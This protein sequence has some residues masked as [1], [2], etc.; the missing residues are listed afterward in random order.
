MLPSP[1]I[2]TASVHQCDGD[3]ERAMLGLRAP[4]TAGRRR[5]AR[6]GRSGR[7]RA[8][9][10]PVAE[11]DGTQRRASTPQTQTGGDRQAGPAP[12]RAPINPVLAMQRTAGNQAVQRRIHAGGVPARAIVGQHAALGNQAVQRLLRRQAVGA[13][14]AV[15]ARRG[16]AAPPA[17]TP[18]V[19][20]SPALLLRSQLHPPAS[21]AP[22]VHRKVDTMGGEWFDDAYSVSQSGTRR[23]ATMH[24]R[25]KP[26]PAVNA[27]LIGLTQS[28]KSL[29]NKT[30]FYPNSDAFYKGRAIKSGD[31]ITTNAATGETDEG[32]RIDQA[33]H[34]R[35][36]LYAAEGAPA[37]DTRLSDTLPVAGDATKSNQWGRHGFRFKDAKGATK[38]QDATLEDTPGI[39]SVDVSKNSGQ[40]FETTALAVKGNQEGTY[41]GSVRWGWRTDDKGVLTKIPFEKVSDGVPSSSFLKAAEIWNTGK[42]STGANNLG[43]PVVDVKVT[44]APVTLAPPVPLRPIPLP[45]GTRLQIVQEFVAPLLNGRVKVVDGPHTGVEGDVDAAEWPNIA[46]ERA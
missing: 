8:G 22:L 24:L 20:R 43:L 34:N 46:D 2:A 21:P 9:R 11:L 15:D 3:R 17:P 36:P 42:A 44:T 23:E 7:P 39:G 26:G 28:V 32:T 29:H 5:P 4:H 18:A 30:P 33:K 45:V 37:A 27:E 31:A 13:E 35:N 6:V 38:E 14:H 25:F 1:N 41:Y 40:I 16:G 10:T 19:Y 12:G